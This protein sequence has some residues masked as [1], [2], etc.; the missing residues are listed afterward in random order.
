MLNQDHVNIIQLAITID[1]EVYAYD[2]LPIEVNGTCYTRRSNQN[3]FE[4]VGQLPF[5]KYQVKEIK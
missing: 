3:R 2:A 4:S 1:A 5:P